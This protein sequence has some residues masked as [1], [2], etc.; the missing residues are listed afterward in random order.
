MAPRDLV[1]P[2]AGPWDE[3]IT[4]PKHAT[5]LPSFADI[6]MPGEMIKSGRPV[7]TLL[8]RNSTLSACRQELRNRATDLDRYLVGP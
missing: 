2:A 3:V 7:L 5:E 1:F 6:P 4:S 8:V